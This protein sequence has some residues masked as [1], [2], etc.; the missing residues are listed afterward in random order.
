MVERYLLQIIH[1]P[2]VAISRTLVSNSQEMPTPGRPPV[3]YSDLSHL[4]F[5]WSRD[6]YS[7][8]S[9]RLFLW[10][11]APLLLIVERC[12]LLVVHQSVV[13][14]SCTSTSNGR[15]MTATSPS[16]SSVVVLT[17]QP[18]VVKLRLQLDSDQRRSDSS[19]SSGI[20]WVQLDTWSSPSVVVV[21]SPHI[22]QLF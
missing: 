6:V 11:L 13:V 8:E 22:R 18:L 7:L 5:S 17:P 15:G 21:S 16:T 12:L 19:T 4:H 2:V 3:S 14:I 9:T 20:C 1:Q 10:S